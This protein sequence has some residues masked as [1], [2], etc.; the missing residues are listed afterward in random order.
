MSDT[1][2]IKVSSPEHR[3][4]WKLRVLF[5]ADGLL[6]IDKPSHL[7]VS[8]EKQ[9][10]DFPVLTKSLQHDLNHQAAWTRSRD[11]HFLDLVYSL[12]FECTGIQLYATDKALHET[13]RNLYG[14]RQIELTFAV[15]VHGHPPEDEFEIDLKLAPHPTRRWQTRVNRTKGKQSLTRCTVKERFRDHTLLECHTTTLRQHQIRVHLK[16]HGCP[17]IGDALYRGNL[18]LLSHLKRKYRRKPGAVEK[19]LID[20]AACHLTRINLTHPGT[21]QPLTIESDYPKDM[22]VGLKCL[23]QFGR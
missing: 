19:P 14:S 22:A 1:S 9:R 12:D 4:F 6:A 7:L 10:A 15:L 18:L 13:L 5:E 21:N 8:P 2:T 17:V 20:R 16:E 3:A 23:Q 11:Y